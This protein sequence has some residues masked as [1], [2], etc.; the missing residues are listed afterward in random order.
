MS[1][2]TNSNVSIADRLAAQKA[3]KESTTAPD[4]ATL[5]ALEEL[6]RLKAENA[7][8][9][10]RLA[11]KA[12]GKAPALSAKFGEKGAVSV[13]GLQRYPATL[14]PHSFVRF[15]RPENVSIV[16]S[17]IA[18]HFGEGS[19]KTITQ[20]DET[21]KMLAEAGFEVAPD[22]VSNARITAEVEKA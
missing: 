20:R 12:T 19:F 10:A 8:L 2:N 11:A 9:T 13:Y 15:L 3:A 18:G 22:A 4:E 1:T 6:E 16:L 17:H 21:V 5:S 7:S 14:Y